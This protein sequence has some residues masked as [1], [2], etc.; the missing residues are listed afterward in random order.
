MKTKNILGA[1]I[2]GNALEFYDFTLYGFFTC[3]IANAFFPFESESARVLASLAAFGAGFVT[4]PF[5]GMLFGFIGD[6]F[7]RKV[8]LSLSILLMG[9]PT[10]LIGL[11]PEYHRIGIFASIAVFLCRLFQGLCTGGEYNGA[12]IFSIE[13]LGRKNPGFIGGCIAGSC[14]LGAFFASFIGSLSQKSFMPEWA[15]RI[16]FLIGGLISFLGY[17]MRKKLTETPEFEKIT[18]ERP[19]HK[20]AIFKA[21]SSNIKS[22]LITFALGSF[23][24]ALSYTFLSFLT[25]YMSKYLKLPLEKVLQYNLAGILGF[26]IGSPLTGILYDKIGWK[27]FY[28]SLALLIFLLSIPL[29]KGIDTLKP[30]MI[31]LAEFMLGLFAGSIAGSGHAFMQTLFPAKDRYMGISFNFSV[32]MGLFGSMTPIIYVH[33]FEKYHASLLFPAYF[34]MTLSFLF[35][36]LVTGFEWK[37]RPVLKFLRIR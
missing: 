17:F 18:R 35:A 33:M 20:T 31:V 9:L 24:G 10:I 6:Y 11:M 16:P 15:W 29:F 34:L 25:V 30:E 2:L 8:A 13:H 1:S 3:V 19:P 27:K 37:V 12:A 21:L 32:G 36:W 5:G 28:R 7:G 22:S 26:M 14:A 4:R 23:N